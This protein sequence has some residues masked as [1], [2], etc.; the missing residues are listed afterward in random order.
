MNL[1]RLQKT[2]NSGSNDS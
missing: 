2:H 1:I